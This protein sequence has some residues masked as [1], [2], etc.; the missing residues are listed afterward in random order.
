M[1]KLVSGIRVAVAVGILAVGASAQA[2]E[3]DAGSERTV[4]IYGAQVQGMREAADVA[5]RPSG[6]GFASSYLGAAGWKLAHG[7]LS[8]AY[9]PAD[10]LVT[11]VA[12]GL[13]GDRKAGAIGASGRFTVGM[14]LAPFNA[15][16]R[17]TL[18]GAEVFTFLLVGDT[19]AAR[20]FDLAPQLTG[21]SLT[22]PSPLT[23][24]AEPTRTAVAARRP[25]PSGD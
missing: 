4:A 25:R 6:G 18:G 12:F 22:G 15:L 21:W 19:N 10:L 16:T 14:V 17:Y 8:M 20:P 9:S 24:A 1:G 2:Q 23:P 13:E 7:L 11:P 5:A 3:M